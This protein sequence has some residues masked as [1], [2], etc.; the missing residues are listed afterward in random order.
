MKAPYGNLIFGQ[1]S[2]FLSEDLIVLY[3]VGVI[4][5]VVKAGFMGNDEIGPGGCRFFNDFDRGKHGGNN[6]LNLLVSLTS[7]DCVNRLMKWCSGNFLNNNVD[8]ILYRVGTQALKPGNCEAYRR[9][10]EQ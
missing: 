4:R 5:M 6:T 8:Y 3:P 10:G 2:L 1:Q 7:L 9:D